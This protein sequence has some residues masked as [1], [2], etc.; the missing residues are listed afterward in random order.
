MILAVLLV[1]YAEKR[2]DEGEYITEEYTIG[3]IN[4]LRGRYIDVTD[5]RLSALWEATNVLDIRREN[6]KMIIKCKRE[7]KSTFEF[8]VE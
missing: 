8:I 7:D 1:G 3:Y 6:G 2:Q 4:D 5:K